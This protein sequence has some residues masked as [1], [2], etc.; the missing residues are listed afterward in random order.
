[1]AQIVSVQVVLAEQKRKPVVIKD[2]DVILAVVQIALV[3]NV[4]QIVLIPNEVAD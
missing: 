4:L 2:V 3:N 1:V